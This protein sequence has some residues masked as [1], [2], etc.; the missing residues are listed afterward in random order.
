MYSTNNPKETFGSINDS[1]VGINP[2]LWV[3]ILPQSLS[4][5]P[6]LKLEIARLRSSFEHVKLGLIPNNKPKYSR[7]S[8]EINPL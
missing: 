7:F 5:L 3:G 4:E 6:L 2:I 8:L 1:K